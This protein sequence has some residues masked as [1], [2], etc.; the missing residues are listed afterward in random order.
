[1]RAMSMS[2]YALLGLNELNIVCVLARLYRCLQRRLRKVPI[3]FWDQRKTLLRSAAVCQG[4][5]GAPPLRRRF[6]RRRFLNLLQ[7][8]V[9]IVANNS[10]L[11]AANRNI[12]HG[13]GAV[14]L[15]AGLRGALLGHDCN[16]AGFQKS[17]VVRD[18]S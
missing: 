2:P 9:V 8:S 11:R 7:H 13:V 4:Q 10:Y 1:C 16:A 6:L 18:G 17:A 12:S 15:D 5:F 3:Y 14:L